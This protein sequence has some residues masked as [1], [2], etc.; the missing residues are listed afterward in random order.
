MIIRKLYKFE[1]AHIVRNCSSKRCKL[2]I[3]GHSYKV[4]LFLKSTSLD[5]GYM[6]YDFGLM[7]GNIK[8]FIDSFDHSYSVWCN[9]SEEFKDFMDNNSAR[10]VTLPWSPSAESYSIMMFYVIDKIINQTIFKNGEGDVE[11][12]AVRV[13]E[14]DTGYAEARKED[15]ELIDFDLNDFGFSDG[16]I[17]EWS[18]DWFSNLKN[19]FKFINPNPNDI[20]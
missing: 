18:S 15:L 14:T 9:E 3:H 8:E 12:Y 16:I 7:K 10:V 1:G 19:G 4:E 5:N 20:Y 2:S 11:V 6:T 13:H 17:E